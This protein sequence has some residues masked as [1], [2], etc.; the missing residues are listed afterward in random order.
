MHSHVATG[1]SRTTRF[2][3]ECS[4]D[5]CLQLMQNVYQMVKYSLINAHNLMQVISD[6]T[7]RV[8]MTHLTVED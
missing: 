4:E 7:L 1:Y 2:S 6:V 8:N 3:P 5:Q